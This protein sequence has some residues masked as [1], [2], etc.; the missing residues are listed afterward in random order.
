MP[1]AHAIRAAPRK[2]W[3]QKSR[4]PA[5]GRCEFQGSVRQAKP[6]AVRPTASST[7]A[8]AIEHAKVRCGVSSSHFVRA[9]VCVFHQGLQIRIEM[10]A[11]AFLLQL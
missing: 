9:D 3:K 2:L 4:G 11:K 5:L 1:K 7:A 6:T 8:P 10:F